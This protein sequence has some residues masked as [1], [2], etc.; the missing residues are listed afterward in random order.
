[1]RPGRAAPTCP[2]GWGRYRNSHNLP[3]WHYECELFYVEKGSLE[4]FCE[5]QTYLVQEGESFFVDSRQVHCM[6]AA[7][8]DTTVAMIVFESGVIGYFARGCTLACPLLGDRYDVYGLFEKLRRELEEKKKLYEGH[9]ALLVS[10]L[11]LEVFRREETK[12]PESSPTAERFRSL[13]NEME[14]K[15]EFFDL[16]AAAAYMGMNPSYFSRLFHKQ[17]RMT[18][19]HYLNFIKVQKAVELPAKGRLPLG[20]GGRHPQRLQHH[21]QLQPHLPRVH[22]LRAQRTARKLFAGQRD[23]R[24]RRRLCRPDAVRVHAARV[25]RPGGRL[26]PNPCPHGRGA[27]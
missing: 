9:T 25:V 4:V 5:R 16:N 8:K 26:T 2:C 12:Q 10:Q 27:H 11:M 23:V 24:P 7:T 3:H 18:F 6:H 21:P 1:M 17:T 20:D 14:K 19:S 22:R 13:L 15:Y